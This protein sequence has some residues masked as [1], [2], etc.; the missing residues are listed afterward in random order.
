MPA[1]SGADRLV[2]PTCSEPPLTTIV[3]PEL[4][5]P[6]KATSAT[7]RCVPETSAFCQLG[8]GSNVDGL[9]P[10]APLPIERSFHTTSLFHVVVDASRRVPATAVT[11]CE[12]AGQLGVTPPLP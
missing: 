1:K 4:G 3:A 8:F 10:V 5:L 11:Y 7:P 2:P 6:S 12:A 9:P